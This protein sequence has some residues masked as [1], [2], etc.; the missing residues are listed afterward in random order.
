M[1]QANVI[2]PPAP[3][4]PP[5]PTSIPVL[6]SSLTPEPSRNPKQDTSSSSFLL[7]SSHGMKRKRAPKTEPVEVTDE[8]DENDDCDQAR[9]IKRLKVSMPLR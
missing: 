8:G 5:L 4:P 2:A 9:E 3:P 6:P 7:T 1:L